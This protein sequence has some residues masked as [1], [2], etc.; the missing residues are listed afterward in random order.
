[1]LGDDVVITNVMD[2]VSTSLFHY[3]LPPSCHQFD[4]V[5]DRSSVIEASQSIYMAGLLVGALVL[6]QMADRY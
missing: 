4:L 1:M 2:Q 3:L 5:C 6:G